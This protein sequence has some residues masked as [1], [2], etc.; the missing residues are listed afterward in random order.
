[1]PT[2]ISKL[3]IA[4][5]LVQGSRRKKPILILIKSFIFFKFLYKQIASFSWNEFVI[6]THEYWNRVPVYALSSL[7]S[8]FH[9]VHQLSILKLDFFCETLWLKISYAWNSKDGVL[10]LRVRVPPENSAPEKCTKF[11]E[12]P[13]LTRQALCGKL[14]SLHQS[15]GAHRLLQHLKGNAVKD[16]D[17][18]GLSSSLAELHV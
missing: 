6:S 15:R 3:W 9:N 14:P 2:N 17:T 1:M 16:S 11:S 12:L 5:K 18:S 13:T 7:L 10:I 4:F 8:I